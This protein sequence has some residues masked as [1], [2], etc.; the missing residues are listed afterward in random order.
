MEAGIAHHRLPGITPADSP[1]FRQKK[2]FLNGLQVVVRGGEGVFGGG[3]GGTPG[4]RQDRAYGNAGSRAGGP[5][6]M[7]RAVVTAFELDQLFSA[8]VKAR[9]SRKQPTCS[10]SVAELTKAH[11]SPRWGTA[12]I[13]SPAKPVLQGAGGAQKLVPCRG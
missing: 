2:L 6:N 3:A 5:G 1:G 4:N 7:S 10:L 8:A 13:T 9:I 11:P 12:S